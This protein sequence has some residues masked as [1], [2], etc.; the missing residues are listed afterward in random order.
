[1]SVEQLD[2][3]SIDVLT[4]HGSAR[5]K[6]LDVRS[7]GQHRKRP[8]R[9]P[10]VIHIPLRELSMRA[11]AELPIDARVVVYGGDDRETAQAEK[12]LE[13]LGFED[14][15]AFRGGFDKLSRSRLI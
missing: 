8:P 10:D 5:F 1:V 6:W 14:V 15:L 2:S 12:A 4:G 7:W 13:K 11:K 3:E 9:D